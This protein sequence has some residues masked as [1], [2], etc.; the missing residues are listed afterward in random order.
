VSV[1]IRGD[2][3]LPTGNMLPRGSDGGR[4]ER[5]REGGAGASDAGKG[6]LRAFLRK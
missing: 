3:V 1:P 2:I 5:D 6:T 4:R